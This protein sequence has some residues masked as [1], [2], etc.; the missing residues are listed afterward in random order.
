MAGARTVIS[1]FWPVSNKGTAEMMSQLYE[2]RDESLLRIFRKIQLRIIA[3]F[4]EKKT[5]D[6]TF[7]WSGLIALGDW[8]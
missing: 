2:K 7:S 6:H 5:V 3:E 1:A 4:R 8:R